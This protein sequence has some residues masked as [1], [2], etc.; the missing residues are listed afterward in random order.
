MKVSKATGADAN[1]GKLVRQ[2]IAGER[3]RIDIEFDEPYAGPIEL[4]AS[5]E[6]EAVD[7]NQ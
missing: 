5:I 3:T 6:P 7:E 1:G 4:S 2:L